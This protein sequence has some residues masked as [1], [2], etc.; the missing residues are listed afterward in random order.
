MAIFNP[1]PP[2]INPPDWTNVTKP[3]SQ[4]EAD[5]STGILLHTIGEGAEDIVK[6]ADT[7]IKEDIKK[8]VDTGVDKLRDAT[9]AQL[10]ALR[11]T[12]IG[13][14]AGQQP[15]LLPDDGT[16]NPPP[17]S[18][19]SGI[20]RINTLGTAMAQ[21]GGKTNDT[22]YS[23]A[24]AAQA[25]Q[26]RAQYPGYRDYIDEQIKSISGMDPANAFMKNLMEDIN[27]SSENS[28][29]QQNAVLTTLRDAAAAGFHDSAGTTAATVY[30]AVNKGLIPIEKGLQWYNQGKQLEYDNK[31]KADL[32]NSRVGDQADDVVVATKDLS[33][34]AGKTADQAWSTMTIGK[35]TDTFETMTKFL[36]SHAGDGTVSDEQARAYGQ[37][38]QTIRDRVAMTLMSEAGK[39]GTITK[40][41]G[42]A[43]K[44]KET[45]SGRLATMDLAIQGVFKDD[46]GS[47][48]S[49]M[50]FNKAIAQDTTNILYNAP[51]EDVRKYNRMVGAINNISPQ[52]GKDFFTQSLLGGVPQ[53]EKEFLKNT[54]MEMITQPD[55]AQGNWTSIQGQ[56]NKAKT[57]GATSP[58]T[59]D[60]MIKSVNYLADPKLATE[61]KLNL[62][63]AFFDPTA[64]AGLLSDK[65]FTMDHYDE[66]LHR[67]VPGKLSV[68]TKLTSSQIAA[69]I[70]ELGKTDPSVVTN[71]RTM[72][73]REFGE[74][75]YSR[76]L[77]DI[78]EDNQYYT[79][80]S[81]YKVKFTNDSGSSPH[82]VS[83]DT[84]TGK[85]LTMT[86]AKQ[87]GAPVEAF[88]R[89]NTGM[90]GL[91]TAYKGTGSTDPTNDVMKAM[92][93]YG[94]QGVPEEGSALP[95]MQSPLTSVRDLV[96]AIRESIKA[97]QK[98]N[99]PKP[100]SETP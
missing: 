82:F 52:F 27:R 4:P 28:K 13:N 7:G 53:R 70:Q 81:L 16:G 68:F 35:G 87:R 90:A 3:I 77:K 66:T 58:K 23:G 98:A 15:S 79:A 42:D 49:H 47:A 95:T 10:V 85:E 83:I 44:A 20:D 25:K 74:Q 39:D 86:E 9:T 60:E 21:N 65:N 50:N 94:Y 30:D 12:Q 59:Y 2:S 41:G 55:A 84:A 56:L 32:R 64:N 51:D 88:N 17:V 99:L 11:N 97:A 34:K 76:E 33:S 63:K 36:Q 14:Q 69:S 73:T 46:W 6:I 8:Q 54:K 96:T 57:S 43:S 92:T 5:K 67:Y 19:Q 75:L 40:L 45:I 1:E 89:L 31:V 78:A 26:I 91:Y 100:K 38:M 22:L 24:L 72:L 93:M 62:A 18:L 80:N 61:Q 71:Y 48:Y 37:Q 29:T